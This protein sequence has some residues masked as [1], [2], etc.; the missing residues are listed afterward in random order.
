MERYLFSDPTRIPPGLHVL[1]V[2]T[3]EGVVWMEITPAE[4]DAV[5]VS[6][7]AAGQLVADAREVLA[8]R[9]PRPEAEGEELR[10]GGQS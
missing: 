4:Y 9:W 7:K 5:I 1:G 10:R 2:P 8:S 3:P 6:P